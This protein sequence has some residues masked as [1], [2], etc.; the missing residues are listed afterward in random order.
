M[1]SD[2]LM[3]L[4]DAADLS[5]FA[6]PLQWLMRDSIRLISQKIEVNQLE[7]GGSRIGGTPDLP[8]NLDWPE[9]EGH[10]LSFIAQIRM[11]DLARVQQV[12]VIPKPNTQQPQLFEF[13]AQPVILRGMAL[14]AENILPKSGILYFFSFD[15]AH[16]ERCD[17]YVNR[18]AWRVIYHES[19][20]PEG[21]ARRKPSV[22]AEQKEYLSAQS[23]S[24]WRE[25][26]LPPVD[27]YEIEPLGLTE[28]Q[29]ED[30]QH[31]LYDLEEAQFPSS[32]THRLLGYPMQIQNNMQEECQLLSEGHYRVTKTGSIVTVSIDIAPSSNKLA[33]PGWK[34]LLQ[35]ENGWGGALYYWLPMA[36]T[37]QQDF[38]KSWLVLQYD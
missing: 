22:E 26:T 37:T 23:I 16:N 24:F 38:S 25:T 30:Y 36:A 5:S 29:L 9:W 35:I 11:S 1:T 28:R 19:E 33:A 34:F 18:N 13:E 8:A 12:E 3:G 31:L 7:L 17:W 20:D 4:I 15:D 6:E 27:A 10:P 21:L 32:P 14:I 2:K